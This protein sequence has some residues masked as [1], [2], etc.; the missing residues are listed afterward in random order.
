MRD[1]WSVAPTRSDREVAFFRSAKR[2]PA[3]EAKYLIMSLILV[4]PL[5]KSARNGKM[6][7]ELDCEEREVA[8]VDAV[9]KPLMRR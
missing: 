7:V 5:C 2:P 1:M 3:R 8:V 4:A 6:K 9:W